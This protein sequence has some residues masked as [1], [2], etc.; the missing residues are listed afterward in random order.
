MA[1]QRTTIEG[2]L[3]ELDLSAQGWFVVEPVYGDIKDNVW[4]QK[5][6]PQAT[7]VENAR[8]YLP[9][10][11]LENLPPDQIKEKILDAIRK[12]L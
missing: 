1:D 4:L 5:K 9:R 12:D 7:A 2:Y 3:D 8:L 6:A 10:K 11:E